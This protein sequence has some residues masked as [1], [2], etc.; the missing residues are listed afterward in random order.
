MIMDDLQQG[1]LYSL[2]KLF[3]SGDSEH[4]DIMNP[5]LSDRILRNESNDSYLLF[6]ICVFKK[7]TN[8]V[9]SIQYQ[10]Y[11]NMYLTWTEYL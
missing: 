10:T 9:W 5:T 3:T 6:Y 8:N 2:H 4:K 1:P 7:S 11:K